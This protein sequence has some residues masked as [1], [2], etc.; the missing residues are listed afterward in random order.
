VG[1]STALMAALGLETLMAALGLETLKL[2]R[3]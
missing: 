1:A 2:S 3:G